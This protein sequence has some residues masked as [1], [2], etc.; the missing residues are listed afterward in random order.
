MEWK[1]RE[2][3]I[4]CTISILCITAFDTTENRIR[5]CL[6]LLAQFARVLSVNFLTVFPSL[7]QKREELP[8]SY[9]AGEALKPPTGLSLMPL[10]ATAQISNADTV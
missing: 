8:I 6:F 2:S 5:H 7:S 1:F 9:S 3:G 4:R 10:M